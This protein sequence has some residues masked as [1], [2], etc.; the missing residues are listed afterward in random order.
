MG[1]IVLAVITAIVSI[2]ALLQYR[3]GTQ[4]AIPPASSATQ[5]PQQ[6]DETPTPSEPATPEPTPA[7]ALDHF[8]TAFAQG[9]SVLVFGDGTGNE[10]DT[11]ILQKV[12]DVK[13]RISDLID[14]GRRSY[15]PT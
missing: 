7:T 8:A 6:T 4:T 12:N 15:E 3:P 2:V 10:D 13:Q 14:R 1:L 5:T 9:H 11:E